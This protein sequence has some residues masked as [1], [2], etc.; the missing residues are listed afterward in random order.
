MNGMVNSKS[1]QASGQGGSRQSKDG[2]ED[3]KRDAKNVD[4]STQSHS[5]TNKTPKTE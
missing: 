4:A 1:R 3:V 5:Q 2:D